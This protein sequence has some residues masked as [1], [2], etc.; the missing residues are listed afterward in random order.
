MKF[1]WMSLLTILFFNLGSQIVQ[2]QTHR[3]VSQ[4]AG[5]RA[6]RGVLT[7]LREDYILKE[8]KRIDILWSNGIGWLLFNERE[9]ADFNI[10]GTTGPMMQFG[11]T[12][13]LFLSSHVALAGILPDPKGGTSQFF[14]EGELGLKVGSIGIS[15]TYQHISNANTR[16][17]NLGFDY[18]GIKI[19]KFFIK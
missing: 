19:R 1:I 6:E 13:H 11:L 18:F 2:A 7:T 17:P 5:L 12:Q 9:N 16:P 15:A 3:S 8:T 14:I 4:A 10:V